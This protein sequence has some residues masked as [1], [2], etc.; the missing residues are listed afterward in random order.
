MVITLARA[1]PRRPIAGIPKWPNTS[2]QLPNPLVHSAS[3]VMARPIPGRPSVATVPRSKTD[4]I[5][6]TAAHINTIMN[7]TA[8]AIT[9]GLCPVARK[10]GPIIRHMP[11]APSAAAMPA[12][13]AMRTDRR[14]SRTAWLR[15]PSSAAISGDAAPTSPVRLQISRLNS[16]TVSDDAASAT[17]PSRATNTTS[18]A[19]TPICSRFAATI[20]AASDRVARASSTRR[21]GGFSN[22]ALP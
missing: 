12:Q 2:T 21:R 1:E 10:I 20:G 3:R 19:K 5:V 16:D 18:S 13:A 8:A 15:R 11:I 14:T 17:G 9:R 22:M 6:G 4:R 7:G